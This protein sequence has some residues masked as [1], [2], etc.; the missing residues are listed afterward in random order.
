MALAWTNTISNEYVCGIFYKMLDE[1]AKDEFG[2]L[3][4]MHHFSSGFKSVQT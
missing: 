4:I 3:D 2:L 1:I